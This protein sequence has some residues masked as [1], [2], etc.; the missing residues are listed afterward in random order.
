MTKA[1]NIRQYITIQKNSKNF[2]RTLLIH[3]NI[4]SI[5]FIFYK[6]Y[7]NSSIFCKKKKK[8]KKE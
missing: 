5:F 7:K 2:I 6:F 4:F 1:T 3:V 8:K